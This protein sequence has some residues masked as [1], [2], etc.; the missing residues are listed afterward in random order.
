MMGWMKE[1]LGNGYD[2]TNA[3]VCADHII[4]PYI[5]EQLEQDHDGICD[6][7]QCTFRDGVDLAA[8]LSFVMRVIGTYRLKAHEELYFDP[9]TTSGYTELGTGNHDTADTFDTL[10]EDAY[11]ETLAESV[12]AA[13][14]GDWWFDPNDIWLQNEHLYADSWDT[15]RKLVTDFQPTLPQLFAGKC[16]PY[17]DWP[18]SAQGFLPSV[19]P[20]RLV[21]L[22]DK[23]NV[24]TMRDHLWYRAQHLKPAEPRS[25]GRL[26]TSP[27][28]YAGANR[29][30]AAGRALFYGTID[31]STALVEIG[32]LPT[33]S[34]TVIGIWKAT[35][36]LQ[37]IDLWQDYPL[38]D[39]FD[40]DRHEERWGRTFLNRFAEEIATAPGADPTRVYLPTQLLTEHFL[41]ATGADGI[42]Y[43]SRHTGQMCCALNILNAA[44]VAGPSGGGDPELVLTGIV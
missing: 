30:S 2:Y 12:R 23:L 26:G 25:P 9:E 20:D 1:K 32:P 14:H 8:V 43:R 33:G 4:D 28:S 10:F 18:E 29:M 40:V 17:I 16:D 35:R 5:R 22:F 39:F 7:C 37:I 27:S 41:A 31:S 11:D 21:G 34:D 42:A 19:L 44:C 15:F 38:P 6:L 36:P 13:L 24:V 3:E